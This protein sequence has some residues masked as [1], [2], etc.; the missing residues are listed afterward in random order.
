[1][2]NLVAI[3]L[4]A[5]TAFS[6]RGRERV[7]GGTIPGWGPGFQFERGKLELFRQAPEAFRLSPS[8]NAYEEGRAAFRRGALR[9]GNPFPGCNPDSVRWDGGWVFESNLRR[10]ITQ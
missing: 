8:T 2:T 6:F 9:T 3:D 4:V 1:M 7:T 10:G 5:G